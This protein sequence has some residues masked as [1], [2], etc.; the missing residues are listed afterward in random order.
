MARR[1]QT[2]LFDHQRVGQLVVIVAGCRKLAGENCADTFDRV[3]QARAEI[4]SPE[5]MKKIEDDA[6]L[7]DIDQ[8]LN[9]APLP[10]PPAP[11]SMGSR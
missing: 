5:V 6:I 7:V 2:L 10:R 9:D 4:A 1:S 8:Q 3:H 11:G